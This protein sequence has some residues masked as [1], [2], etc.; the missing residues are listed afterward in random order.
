MTDSLIRN[1]RRTAAR[2]GSWTPFRDLLGF[3]PFQSMRGF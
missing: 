1:D 3:D 2:M